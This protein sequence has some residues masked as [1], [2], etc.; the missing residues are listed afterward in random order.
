M[1]GRA[2]HQRLISEAAAEHARLTNDG[3]SEH[4][5]LIDE[6]TA[7]HQRLISE[8]EEQRAGILA[9][10]NARRELLERRVGD[11][12]RSQGEYR[13]RLRALVQQQLSALDDEGWRS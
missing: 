7:E 2:K 1:R 3:Q 4:R 11:L 8:A 6:A 9:D 5:R 10:L 13:D 12:D